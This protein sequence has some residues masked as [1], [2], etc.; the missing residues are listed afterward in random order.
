MCDMNVKLY[1]EIIAS[2][3]SLYYVFIPAFVYIVCKRYFMFFFLGAI[4]FKQ[5]FKFSI[6]SIWLWRIYVT[7][8]WKHN[9]DEIV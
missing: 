6:L 4:V 7:E 1:Y 3:T 2:F 9:R 5:T 8:I